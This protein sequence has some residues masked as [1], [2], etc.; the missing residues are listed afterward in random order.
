MNDEE[1]GRRILRPLDE[2][3]DAPSRVDVTAAVVAGTR[4]R[5]R[6][7][8]AVT[9]AAAAVGLAAASIP[10]VLSQAA[11]VAPDTAGRPS[12]S[13]KPSPS[14]KPKYDRTVSVAFPTSCTGE[15]LPVPGG[16]QSHASALDPTGRYATYRTYSA[17]RQPIIWHEGVVT[18]VG[19]PGDDDSLGSINSNGV[20]VGQV[21]KNGGPTA[22]VAVGDRS[23]VLPGGKGRDARAINEFGVIVGGSAYE[24]APV[25]WDSPTSQPTKLPLPKDVKR[26]HAYD[27]DSDGTVVGYVELPGEATDDMKAAGV[28]AERVAYL[29]PVKG[30]G[31]VLE[32]PV[33]PGGVPAD[34]YDARGISNGWVVGYASSPKAAGT[35]V[36]VR[37]DL[38]TGKAEVLPELEWSNGVNAHGWVAGMGRDQHAVLTDG[39]RTVRL[40]DVFPFPEHGM[41]FAQAVSDDGRTVVGNVDDG[42]R[43]G[44]QQAVLW[45]CS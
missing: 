12:A 24:D 7:R 29:W 18:K 10:V 45:R 2:E 31:R 35:P 30:P 26:G 23:T 41:N 43:D 21:W 14:P 40:P 44:L 28:R 37:W 38:V 5:R 4:R 6:Q 22:V 20:A 19:K 1:Y 16:G 34:Y 32:R 13:A 8:L 33:L 11:E 9:A 3:P 17:G 27:V 42:T 36:G 15:A 39:T 25:R